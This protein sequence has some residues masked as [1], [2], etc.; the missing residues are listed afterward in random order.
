MKQLSIIAVL[1]AT[2]MPQALA[3]ESVPYAYRPPSTGDTYLPALGTFMRAAQFSHIKLWYAGKPANWALAGYELAQIEDS[4]ANA[5]RLY[6]NIPVEKIDMIDQP[7]VALSAAIK[8]RDGARFS[9][10]FADLT[11]ACNSCHEAAQVGFITIEV[12]TSSPF[13]DQSF[14]P[15][16][17]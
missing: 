1:V 6:Q 9:R 2:F 5:A 13:S 7:L 10:A 3:Q 12:P 17:K 15:K 16:K 11:A 4:L 8:A 14:T